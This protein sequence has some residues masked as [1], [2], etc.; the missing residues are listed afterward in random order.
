ML[1]EVKSTKKTWLKFIFLSKKKKKQT[2]NKFFS[3]IFLKKN[4]E[5]QNFYTHN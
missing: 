1:H 3:D 2:L 4:Q 5:T